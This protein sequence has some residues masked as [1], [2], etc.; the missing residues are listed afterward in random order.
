M[1]SDLVERPR[2]E[3]PECYRLTCACKLR[4][5]ILRALMIE[6]NDQVGHDQYLYLRLHV[7]VQEARIELDLVTRELHCHR[8]GHAI[9]AGAS[10]PG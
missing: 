9:S 7:A 4:T 8:E 6:M 10:A 5:S 3:C 1:T 2:P